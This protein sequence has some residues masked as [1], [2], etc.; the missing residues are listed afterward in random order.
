MV[1]V[2]DERFN[3][4]VRLVLEEGGREAVF[5][6]P[7]IPVHDVDVVVGHVHGFFCE[8]LSKEQV[9]PHGWIHRR[10]LILNPR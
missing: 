4:V 10:K 6:Y 1:G 5:D 7:D 9:L 2:L 3:E 8:S